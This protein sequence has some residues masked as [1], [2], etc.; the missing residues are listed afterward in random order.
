MFFHLL[1]W[2][3]SLINQISYSFKP[4]K[5]DS[6]FY[7][8]THASVS[9]TNPKNHTTSYGI[10]V[11]G[12][13]I[14]VDIPT[15]VVNVSE[16]LDWKVVNINKDRLMFVHKKKPQI[17]IN[18][19]TIKEIAY[20]GEL[21][22]SIIAFGDNEALHV[23]TIFNPN[24]TGPVPQW[25]YLELLHF[26]DSN[27]KVSVVRSL[28]W[29]KD[30]DWKFIR[31][32]KMTDYIHFEDKLYLAISRSISKANSQSIN[33]E[34]SIIRL[35]LD[36]GIELISSAVEIHFTRPEFTTNKIN[37][38][39]FVF[40][41][42]TL[43]R[44]SHELELHTTQVQSP[45]NAKVYNIYAM[46]DIIALFEQTANE[47]ASGSGNINLLQYHLRSEV[48][49]CKK[50]SY[51][52]CSTKGNM[53][54]SKNVSR[55]LVGQTTSFA[56]TFNSL[57]TV[58]HKIQFVVL[59]YPYIKASILMLTKP[60]YNTSICV[61][62]AVTIE[63]RNFIGNVD[64]YTE[65]AE[66][67][68]HVNKHP[69]ALLI[70]SKKTGRV[71]SDSIEVCSNLNSC[72]RCIMYGLYFDC[73]WSNSICTLGDQP[74]N[75]TELTV[76]YCFKVID[77]SPLIFNTSLPRLLKIQLD[78]PVIRSSQEQ[79]VIRAGHNHCTNFTMN[80]P[81]LNCS[82]DLTES[83]EFKI[84]VSLQ[85][86]RYADAATLSAV[87]NDKVNISAPEREHDN[88]NLTLILIFGL[89]VSSFI[90]VASYTDQN[91][92]HLKEFYE[93]ARSTKIMQ[94]AT[95]TMK[96]KF[97]PLM[98]R[99]A[100]KKK[101]ISV[102]SKE[103]SLPM[104]S[105][106]SLSKKS[107]ITVTD[108]GKIAKKTKEARKVSFSMETLPAKKKSTSEI[109]VTNQLEIAPKKSKSKKISR[110]R[111]GSSLTMR[112]KSVTDSSKLTK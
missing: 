109:A 70:V 79:L 55:V 99:L 74:K 101:S 57:A 66:A 107:K 86:D 8:K 69:H 9:V 88:N 111:R 97:S 84:D 12:Q 80:G 92:K 41:F 64:N 100:S 18:R 95:E 76:D 5:H 54:P 112:S 42:G 3:V 96:S 2:I 90:L 20:S 4:P 75:K 56:N 28:K 24:L 25:N 87:S 40:I 104:E 102:K 11:A 50:T 29:L 38:A 77:I 93:R 31:E 85:N 48:G 72:T 17:L 68:F 49:K 62:S 51:K 27:E 19:Q 30:D 105:P 35:C 16:I 61:F 44:E 37:D 15:S 47:C 82:M 81:F 14:T 36:K 103:F 78:K 91:K 83:G 53:V 98:K 63:C 58:F 108:Q 23:P 6:S 71:Y 21:S 10:Y 13:T 39:I 89:L 34:I 106:K 7:Y 60:I 46:S 32:W 45:S 59:P 73:I 26:D 110:S 94:T 33:R 65:F 1:I 67:D 52:S 43:F 22:G